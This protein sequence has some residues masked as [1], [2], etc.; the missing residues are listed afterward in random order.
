LAVKELSR[1]LAVK[2]DVLPASGQAITL[3]GE[4]EDG[5]VITG[6]SRIPRSGKRIKRVS[7]EPPDVAALPDAIAAIECAELVVIGPGSL[8]TS[9]LPNL[10]VKGIHD[11]LEKLNRPKVYICNLMTQPGETD[12]FNA[13]QH[14]QV[15]EQHVGKKVINTVVVNNG[16]IPLF[17]REKYLKEGAV[18]VEPSVSQLKTMGYDVIE[19]AYSQVDKYL[20]HHTDQLSETLM[21][22]LTREN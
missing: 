18:P 19:G 21:G 7:I 16:Y 5:T 6:E 17:I 8:Y 13:S 12:H 15:I 9:V 22:L 3:V 14:L 11:A 1:V 10:L 20:R 2:G 4:M